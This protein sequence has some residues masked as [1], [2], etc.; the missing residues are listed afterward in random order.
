M[1][2][3]VNIFMTFDCTQSV[4]TTAAERLV[5]FQKNLQMKVYLFFVRVTFTLFMI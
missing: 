2:C 4:F 5:D 1:L 3:T